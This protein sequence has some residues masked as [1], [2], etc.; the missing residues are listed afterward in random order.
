MN[1]T[2][3]ASRH[4]LLVH[5]IVALGLA[6]GLSSCADKELSAPGIDAATRALRANVDTIVVIYAENRGF[7]QAAL[8]FV[9]LDA[10]AYEASQC[11]APVWLMR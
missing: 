8:R 10:R 7:D 6:V 11:G 5:S 1:T 3:C 2:P 4:S 9:A